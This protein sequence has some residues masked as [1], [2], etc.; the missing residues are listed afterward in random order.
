MSMNAKNE[1]SINKVRKVAVGATLGI[2]CPSFH[3]TATERVARF[4]SLLEK[5]GYHYKLGKSTRAQA[6][7]LAGPDE[8]RAADLMEMFLDDEIDAIICLLGGFGA[9]RIIDK[10]DYQLIKKHP[11]L[12]IGFSDITVL[13]NALYFKAN[14][15]SVHGLVG[16]FLGH[17]EIDEDSV[18]DFFNLFTSDF[19]GR[20]LKNNTTEA[21]TLVRGISEGIIVGGNL[22]LICAL[23][24][25]P[26]EIDFTGKIVLIEDVDEKPYRID[27]MFSSLRLSGMLAKANGYIFGKFT[28]CEGPSQTYT[29]LINEY[30]SNLGVPVITEFQT[31]HELPFVNVP[32]GLKAQLDADQKTITILENSYK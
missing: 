24:G 16:T 25:T 23:L 28:G 10:L 12:F 14:I 15:P 7:Y 6:G 11:K 21:N 3:T 29:E 22:S 18:N 13:L 4:L 8:V 2:V 17:P 1:L 27:R 19:K 9:T 30:F 5:N 26:Y 32:I 31:G 20:V